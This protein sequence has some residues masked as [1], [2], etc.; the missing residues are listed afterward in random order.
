MHKKVEEL[1]LENYRLKKELHSV[2]IKIA[3][4]EHEFNKTVVFLINVGFYFNRK[5]FTPFLL[6]QYD[7]E[8]ASSEIDEDFL[9]IDNIL[10]ENSAEEH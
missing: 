6:F 5:Y 7:M 3:E 9:N 4:C 10:A 8:L 2:N 1:T